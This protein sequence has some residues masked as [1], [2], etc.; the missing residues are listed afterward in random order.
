[1]DEAG[2]RALAEARADS[3]TFV[4]AQ[5]DSA[6]AEQDSLRAIVL[7]VVD[8]LTRGAE[9]ARVVLANSKLESDS[10]LAT[11]SSQLDADSIQDSTRAAIVNAVTAL[12]NEAKACNSVLENCETQV[13]LLST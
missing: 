9:Q 13:D 1:M 12:Q 5:A 4:L 7:G 2:Q 11:L 6:Y 3:I 10:A 8:S